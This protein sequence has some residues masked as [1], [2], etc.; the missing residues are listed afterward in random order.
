MNMMSIVAAITNLEFEM[1]VTQKETTLK[2]VFLCKN[3]QL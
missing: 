1:D 3:G 2:V